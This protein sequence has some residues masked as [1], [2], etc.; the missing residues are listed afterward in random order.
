MCFLGA[1]SQF[2][3]WNPDITASSSELR[4]LLTIG[5]I[6]SWGEKEEEE[7]KKLK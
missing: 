2:R 7:F 6:F 1:L 5:T 3:K 4:K